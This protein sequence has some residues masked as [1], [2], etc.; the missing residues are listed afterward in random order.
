MI[1]NKQ[2]KTTNKAVAG[3]QDDSTIMISGF[4]NA[5]NPTELVHA[6]IKLGAKNLT[7]INNNAGTGHLGLAKLLQ[8]GRVRK[9]ICSFPRSANSEVFQNLYKNGKIDL[10]VVPQGTLAER[11]RAGGAGI[12][13]FYTP[14][15]AKTIVA[16]G[17]ET[18]IIDGRHFVFEHPI[19]ADYSLIKADQADKWGNLI[20]NKAARN[21]APSMCMA[22]KVTIVQ[23]KKITALGSINPEHVVTPCIFV[24]RIVQISNPINETTALP[25]EFIP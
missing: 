13:G 20:Y 21:F 18:R 8:L 5:G 24:D 15:S 23:V 22:A 11:I 14:T 25:N 4:G 17:K 12:G 9:I 10:E 3:I 19:K 16:Q 2:F 6:L 7:I 1:F